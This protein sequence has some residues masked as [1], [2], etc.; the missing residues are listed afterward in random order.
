LT[1]A[2]VDAMVKEI[3]DE[4]AAAEAAKRGGAAAAGVS[5]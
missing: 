1:D 3:E 4:K 2:E 5:S